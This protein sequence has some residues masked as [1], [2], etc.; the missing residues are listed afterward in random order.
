M[1]PVLTQ[2]W[3]DTS[4][5]LYI[6]CNIAFSKWETHGKPSSLC[7]QVCFH[8]RSSSIFLGGNMLPEETLDTDRLFFP[9][10][11]DITLCRKRFTECPV[12]IM[13]NS[14]N[15]SVIVVNV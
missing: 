6:I 2:M 9:S 3:S 10:G 11:L 7:N 14:L 12:V 15:S 1:I 8:H 4:F 13:M 5:S